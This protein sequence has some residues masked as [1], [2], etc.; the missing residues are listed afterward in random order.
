[1]RILGIFSLIDKYS[2]TGTNE[3][4]VVGLPSH[5]DSNSVR[6][7][8]GKGAAVILEV[9]YCWQVYYCIL[10]VTARYR[11]TLVGSQ[12]TKMTELNVAD[13]KGIRHL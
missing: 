12:K 4:T 7:S 11:T 3:L 5:V 1:M 9:L 8:G 10:N 2:T 6:V 13:C